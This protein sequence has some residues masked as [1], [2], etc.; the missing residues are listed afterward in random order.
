MRRRTK[1]KPMKPAAPKLEIGK[2]YRVENYHTG[3]FTGICTETD[4]WSARIRVQDPKKT[5][6]EGEAIV[7]VALRLATSVEELFTSPAS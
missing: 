7:E 4:R 1:S 5:G 6:L 2:L 3:S